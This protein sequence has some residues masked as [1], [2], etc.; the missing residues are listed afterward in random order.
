[1]DRHD[2]Q[3][4]PLYLTRFA[5]GF[6]FVTLITLLPEYITLYDPSGLVVGLFTTA[7]TLAQTLAVVPLAWAGDRYDKRYV[8]LGG[9]GIGIAVYLGFTFVASSAGFV[10]ARAAQGITVTATSLMGL[11]LVGEL[12]TKE[13]RANHIGKANAARFAA[14][15][16]GSLGAGALYSV[17][18]FGA[19]YSV[20]TGL[21]V[22]AGVGVV[23]FVSPDETRIE[24]FP[25]TDLALNRRLL[26]LSSF[27]A[28]Y[29][30]AVT[31]VRT[32]VPIYAGVTA[33]SGGL[34]MVSIAVG[35]VV[36]AE[37]FTNMLC[38][39]FTGRLSDRFGRA[40]FVFVGGGFYGLV[41]LAVPFT[42]TIAAW[43]SLPAALPIL[44]AT[45][46][47]FVPLVICNGLLGVA[48]SIR[49]PASMALFADE[50]TDDGGVASSFGI[51][52]LVWRPGSILAPLLGG[53]LMARVGMQ[54][55]FFVGGTVAFAGIATFLGVLSYSHGSDALTQW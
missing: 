43:L 33:A 24:G 21:L 14:G 42:P 52:E 23:A 13:T 29:A 44:G 31:L 22:V 7:F 53:L 11:A 6:G 10:L 26:T 27:R 50:G 47:A 40:L 15:I 16:A 35:A 20:V 51:R 9:F 39:P 49:E 19:V 45:P 5:G 25:F 28:Q 37:K 8:L 30:V 12:A 48:D 32:W 17:A 2:L 46:P 54:W 41:A 4:Y 36:A 18:G 55:V 3:F 1:V 34:G 38:Q